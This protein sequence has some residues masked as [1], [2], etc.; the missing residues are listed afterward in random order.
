MAS[1]NV[2]FIYLEVFN[3][4]SQAI[5]LAKSFYPKYC[6]AFWVAPAS[7]SRK[8]FCCKSKHLFVAG[9][10]TNQFEQCSTIIWYSSTFLPQTPKASERCNLS[11]P[12]L[13]WKLSIVCAVSSAHYTLVLRYRLHTLQNIA[14]RTAASAFKTE[15]YWRLLILLHN[16]AMYKVEV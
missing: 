7:C 3:E 14:F 8:W 16:Y 1:E 12:T 15:D 2:P 13:W 6:G 5:L 4:T 11:L 9:M 10:E